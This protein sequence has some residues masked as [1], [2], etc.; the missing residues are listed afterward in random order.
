MQE[1]N[2]CCW[3]VIVSAAHI[4]AFNNC[5]LFFQS[6]KRLFVWQGHF[7]PSSEWSC[8][9]LLCTQG[10]CVCLFFDCGVYVVVHFL[11]AACTKPKCC[12]ELIIQDSR[13]AEQNGGRLILGSGGGHIFKCSW[14]IMRSIAVTGHMDECY[15]AR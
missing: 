15:R 3:L 7:N 1:Q 11:L 8:G 12:L 13:K 9:G 10:E 4:F 5:Q 6:Y 2:L 14:F